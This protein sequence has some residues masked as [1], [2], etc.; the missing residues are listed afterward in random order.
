MKLPDFLP[1]DPDDDMSNW[2]PRRRVRVAIGAVIITDHFAGDVSDYLSDPDQM[3]KLVDRV[4]DWA[5]VPL[6]VV[7]QYEAKG[8]I[9]KYIVM[10]QKH[11]EQL[12]IPEIWDNNWHS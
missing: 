4:A 7:V 12:S 9:A 6:E 8:H 2:G 5:G 3:H 10:A 11:V 1:K